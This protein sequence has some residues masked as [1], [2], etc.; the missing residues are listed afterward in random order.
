MVMIMK[1]I[2]VHGLSLGMLAVAIVSASDASFAEDLSITKTYTPSVINVVST[3]GS[4]L[5]FVSL[6]SSDFPSGTTVVT[7][8]KLRGVEWR[9][10]SYPQAI[11]EKVELCYSPPYRSTEQHCRWIR[12]DSFGVLY[13]FNDIRFNRGAQVVMKHHVEGGGARSSFPAGNDSVTF[14]YSY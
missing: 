13:D 6:S 12:P 14:H 4:G 2:N 10:T 5:A 1:G 7:P 3:G 11:G 9:T 8:M